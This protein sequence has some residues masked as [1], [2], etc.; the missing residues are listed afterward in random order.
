LY[1]N[2]LLTRIKLQKCL[3]AAN[4]L[5]QNKSKIATIESIDN[6][7]TIKALQ[8]FIETII[9]FKSKLLTNNTDF[10]KTM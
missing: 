10:M 2:L 7:Q 1:D 5:P 4:R 6:S 9:N 8:Q 3:V